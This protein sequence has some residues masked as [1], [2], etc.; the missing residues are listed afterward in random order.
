M[1]TAT[2]TAVIAIGVPTMTNSK[3]GGAAGSS[4]M[5]GM[6]VVLGFVDDGGDSGLLVEMLLIVEHIEPRRRYG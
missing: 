2:M 6:I 5:V 1:T 4:M 3:F